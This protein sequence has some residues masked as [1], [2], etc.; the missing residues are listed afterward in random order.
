MSCPQEIKKKQE[1]LRSSREK[2]SKNQYIVHSP[3]HSSHH[4]YCTGV[5]A[6]TLL[7]IGV[8]LFAALV[9]LLVQGSV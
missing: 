7:V 2:K 3:G 8:I 5:I 9:R 4:G 1:E 6:N